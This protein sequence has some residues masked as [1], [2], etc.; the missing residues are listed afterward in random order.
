[1]TRRIA[2]T[3]REGLERIFGAVRTVENGGRSQSPNQPRYMAWDGEGGTVV[4]SKTSAE[5]AKGTAATLAVYSGAHGSETATSETVTAH[6]YFGKVLANKWVMIGQ[7]ADGRYYLI[8]PEADQVELVYTAEIVSTTS[9]GVTTS[10]LVFRR[11]KVWVHSIEEGTA[12][13]IGM[14]ECVTPYSNPN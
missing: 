8:A 2:T 11:K 4:L 10:K 12:V 9:A 6:N 1:M 13:E 14:T 3:N 5:W 7:N